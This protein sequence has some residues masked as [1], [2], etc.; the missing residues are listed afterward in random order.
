MSDDFQ[1][2]LSNVNEQAEARFGKENWNTAVAALHRA[3]PQGMS[4][5]DMTQILARPDPAGILYAGGREQL[6][7]ESDAGNR[8]SELAY[9]RIRQQ[10]REQHRKLKGRG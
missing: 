6:L 5:A 2:K 10:E 9:S 8:E 7:T 4:N 3:L 1:K